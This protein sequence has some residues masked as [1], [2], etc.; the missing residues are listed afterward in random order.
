MTENLLLMTDSYKPTHAHQ[1][2]PDMTHV[3]SFFSSRGGSSPALVSGIGVQYL[4]RR[5]LAPGF[6]REDVSEAADVLFQHFGQNLFNEAGMLRTLEAHGGAIPV[7]IK[8]V[9]EGTVVPPHHAVM[10]IE[11]T[12]DLLPFWTNYI[13]TL[14][15]Q[16]WYPSSVATRSREMRA[17]ILSSL[18]KT[19]TPALIDYKLHDFGVRGASS[20]ESAAIGGFAHLANFKGTD[21]LPAIMLA[22]KYY[23]CQM[24][25]HS[26]PASE[27]ST[28]TSW[29][30]EHEVDA[31]RNMLT[32]YPKGI[33]SVVSD[34]YDIFNAC[35][36]IWGR[37]L[38]P[39]VLAR[40]GVLVVRP[41]SGDPIS[42]LSHVLR[43]LA[44]KFGFERN[45]KGYKVLHPSVRVIQ[46]DGIDS[47]SLD[48]ILSYF[49]NNGWSA[50]NITFGSGGGLLQ[51]GLTRDT[52]RFAFKASAVKRD[53]VW[54]DVMKSPITDP[55][56]RS[57]PGR[58]ALIRTADGSFETVP[59]ESV[60]ADRNLLKTVFK[61]GAVLNIQSLDDIRARV[62]AP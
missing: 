43:I 9:P 27:H 14:M 6:T 30:R 44:D 28:M 31:Y 47:N 51:K 22:R 21:N 37:I 1:Y 8:A 48:A 59:L 10:T 52:H 19:G 55:T 25:G 45:D 62:V 58:L 34:S 40:D 46:G 2:P 5:Y 20:P 11:N 38:K 35:E 26:V 16:T 17:R 4:T 33:V 60:S 24:A 29:G 42:V 56:K 12:D 49:E 3:H 41:D 23:G 61:N 36:Q 50:D 39:N 13:E 53:G 54:L 57:K 32:L 7:E 18:E 15:V